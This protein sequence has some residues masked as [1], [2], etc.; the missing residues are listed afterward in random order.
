MK[1]FKIFLFT[2]TSFASPIKSIKIFLS[3]VKADITKLIEFSSINA[4][5]R[6]VSINVPYETTQS[7]VGT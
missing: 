3:R 5:R 1:I 7:N 2:L 6:H 4:H